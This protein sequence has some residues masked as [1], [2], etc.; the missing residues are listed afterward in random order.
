MGNTTTSLTST[1][2]GSLN[3]TGP[4]VTFYLFHMLPEWIAIAVLFGFNVREIFVTGL[5][6]DHRWRDETPEEK[7]KREAKMDKKAAQYAV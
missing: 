2:P 1:A 5:F 7:Q 3:T 4:R 6:G